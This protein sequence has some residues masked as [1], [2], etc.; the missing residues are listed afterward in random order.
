MDDAAAPALAPHLRHGLL[1]QQQ[2]RARVDLE[3]PV[4]QLQRGLH[5]RRADDEPAGVVDQHVDAAEALDHG[6]RQGLDLHRVGDVGLEGL[7]VGAGGHQT[8]GDRVR[9]VH[10]RVPVHGDP[11]ALGG[12]GLCGRGP[13]AGARPG[14]QHHLA[15][16]IVHRLFIQ[17]RR[18]GH[19]RPDD[20]TQAHETTRRNA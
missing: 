12:E 3:D 16:K 20:L 5:Q 17:R 18:D 15:L 8:R 7:R 2:R 9:G 1:A 4:D 6:L 14:D 10:L 19:E 13:D 11:R